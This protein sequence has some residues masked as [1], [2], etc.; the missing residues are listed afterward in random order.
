MKEWSAIEVFLYNVYE[1]FKTKTRYCNIN[2]YKFFDGKY[3]RVKK[4]LRMV[5]WPWPWQTCPVKKF[6]TQVLAE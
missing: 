5:I 1:M 3:K 6:G 4:L 2:V